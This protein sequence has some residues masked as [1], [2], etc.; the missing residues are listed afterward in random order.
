MNKKIDF[1]L[2]WVDC[3]DKNW[4]KEKKKYLN[5][6]EV[7]NSVIRYQDWEN[8]KY[9]FRSV[10]KYAPWVNKVHL[11]TNGQVPS[12]L[13][14]QCP[15]LNLVKHSDYMPFD[16][17]PTFNSCAIEVGLHNISTL[18]DHFVYFNDDIFLT[19]PITEEYYFC[20]G[21][22]V[23]TLG[24]TRAPLS[25]PNSVFSSIIKNNNDI[26]FS[27]FNKKD[28]VLNS[29][30]YWFRPIYGKTFFR[31]LFYAVKKGRV[32]FTMPH[33]SAPFVKED[34]ERVWN[35]ESDKLLVSQYNR[36][37][38]NSDLTHHLFR[39]WRMCTGN[40]VP[41]KIKGKY[42]SVANVKIAHKISS[43]ILKNKYPEICINE[44][45]S[46]EVFENAKKII[47]DAFEKVLPQKSIFELND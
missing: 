30:F 19:S 37:R 1:V 2:I 16:S 36:F 21:I 28:L 5:S 6:T 17:L 42:Y 24:F 18:S 39:N 7:D 11:V 46:G 27:H 35:E 22:P 9:W 8:L 32:G 15:K 25:N 10:E 43:A 33:L 14:I 47:N 31:S 34:F 44:V 13:N 38:T 23:D 26:I 45:C 29:F 41:R 40:F 3:N 12:W 20:K 4:Q